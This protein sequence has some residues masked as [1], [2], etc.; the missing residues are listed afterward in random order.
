MDLGKISFYSRKI[1]RIS[2]WFITGLGL[3]QAST[4]II[5]EYPSVFSFIPLA[6][7]LQLHMSNGIFFVVAFLVSMVTGLLM[8]F[9]PIVIKKK[10]PATPKL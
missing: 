6:P 9:I 10:Q 2:L 5:M 7:T 8:Y 4:G 1:H 3:I